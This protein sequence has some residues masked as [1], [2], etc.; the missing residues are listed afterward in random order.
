[1]GTVN[2]PIRTVNYSM[3]RGYNMGTVNYSKSDFITL[4]IIPYRYE[5]FANDPEITQDAIEQAELHG[6]TM[7]YELLDTLN[8]YY[9]CDYFNISGQLR[10]HNFHYFHV[11]IKPGYYEGFTIDIEFNYGIFFESWDDRR[12]A[13]K[14]I[15]EIKKFLKDCAGL[16]MV[17]CFP[18]LCTTY[19]DYAETLKEISRATKEMR[20]TVKSVPT[21]NQYNMSCA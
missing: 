13:N 11:D 5:D 6:T 4:G 1:M 10:R 2:Y 15:T 20:E 8:Y 7:E 21:W 19:Y 14:E 12:D 9:E 3:S 18:G 17:A 16:G